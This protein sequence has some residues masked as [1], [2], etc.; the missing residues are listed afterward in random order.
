MKRM[1]IEK[2]TLAQ[3]AMCNEETADAL[4]VLCIG[5]GSEPEQYLPLPQLVMHLGHRPPRV[6]RT[7]NSLIRKGLVEKLPVKGTATGYR[8]SGKGRVL[9]QAIIDTQFALTRT[10]GFNPRHKLWRVGRQRR[11]GLESS[12]KA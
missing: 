4:A 3:A 9:A 7:M 6:R 1:K 2:S 8:L 5:G 12:S 11:H 10:R